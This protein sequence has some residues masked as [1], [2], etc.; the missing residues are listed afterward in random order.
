M[1]GV[2]LVMALLFSPGASAQSIANSLL[3]LGIKLGGAVVESAVDSVSD[4]MRDPEAERRKAQEEKENAARQYAQF[5]AEV[6]SMKE[7]TALQRERAVYAYKDVQ[8]ANKIMGELIVRSEEAQRTQR[9]KIFTPT[10]LLGAAIESAASSP[11]VAMRQANQMVKAGIPQQ[12]TKDVMA[13]MDGH[14]AANAKILLASA[15]AA[16]EI[17]TPQP[18][19]SEAKA[20]IADIQAK[21][22]AEAKQIQNVSETPFSQDRGKRVFVEFINAPKF[23]AHLAEQLK[24]Q[25]LQVSNTPEEA[26]VRY[27]FEGDLQIPESQR[28]SA[29]Q[30]DVGSFLEKPEAITPPEKKTSGQVKAIVGSIFLGLARAQGSNIPPAVKSADDNTYGQDVVVVASRWAEG[31][32]IRVS[33]RRKQRTAEVGGDQI[34]QETTRDLFWLLG[35]EYPKQ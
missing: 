31:K 7:L 9:A 27:R 16:Q 30:V 2:F 34:I 19:V 35:L 28:Y 33:S 26:E 6:E 4:A 17:A 23:S 12:Q 10:G 29:L 8:A 20:L 24:A 1:F 14:G 11:A 21:Q 13:Q 22:Q 3:Q 32:E 15:G 18:D 25:G 5:L